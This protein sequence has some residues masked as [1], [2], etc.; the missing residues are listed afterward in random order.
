MDIYSNL[1]VTFNAAV[2]ARSHKYSLQAIGLTRA[3]SELESAEKALRIAESRRDAAEQAI[4]DSCAEIE[5]IQ[6]GVN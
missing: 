4:R 2:W 5:E 1:R 6:K 3:L